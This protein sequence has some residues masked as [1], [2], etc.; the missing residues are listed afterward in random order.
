M[1]CKCEKIRGVT[2]IDGEPYCWHCGWWL[3][4]GIIKDRSLKFST[5]VNATETLYSSKGKI[6]SRVPACRGSHG[7]LQVHRKKGVLWKKD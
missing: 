3:S 6:V 5:E 4:E 7:P 1:R 2:I